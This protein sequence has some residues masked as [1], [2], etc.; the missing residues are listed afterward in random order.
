MNV[1]FQ[2]NFSTVERRH[3]EGDTDI[4]PA[5]IKQLRKGHESDRSFRSTQI[6][7]STAMK[8]TILA[9][10]SGAVSLLALSA[11]VPANAQQA[12]TP[13]ASSEP[14]IYLNQGWS[15][16]D[17]EWY[18]HFSQGSAFLSYDIYLNLEVAGSQDLLRSGARYGL[19]PGPASSYNP[20]GLPI[21]ISKTSGCDPDQR[22][23]SRRLCRRNLCGVPR[24]GAE[25]QGQA[26]SYSRWEFAYG[27]SAGS[28]SGPR[29]RVASDTDRRSEIQPF[30]G[31]ARGVEHG[32]QGHAAKAS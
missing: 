11:A 28:R 1:Q 16:E 29:R 9:F 2:P 10:L 30:G 5:G 32:C 22:L 15:Q 14:V 27:R 7:R 18:Y 25:V 26:H 17:R 12:G 8:R 19:L 31:A 3:R 21:G 6:V 23:A 20:D 4:S 13:T 24:R